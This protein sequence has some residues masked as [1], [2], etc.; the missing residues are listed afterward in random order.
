D[1]LDQERVVA[2]KTAGKNRSLSSAEE[3][4]VDGPEAATTK[5][6]L[7]PPPATASETASRPTA[8]GVG[9][10]SGEQS[11]SSSDSSS[12]SSRSDRRTPVSRLA[13]LRGRF[14]SWRRRKRS[15]V[16]VAVADDEEDDTTAGSSESSNATTGAREPALDPT[17]TAVSEKVVAQIESRGRTAPAADSETVAGRSDAAEAAKKSGEEAVVTSTAPVLTSTPPPDTGGGDDGQQQPALGESSTK[18]SVGGAAAAV[19]SSE[20]AAPLSGPR[21]PASAAALED[22]KLTLPLLVEDGGSVSLEPRSVA[23]IGPPEQE[24]R[25]GGDAGRGAAESGNS[26]A[27]ASETVGLQRDGSASAA[28]VAVLTDDGLSG[29]GVVAGA[30]AGRAREDPEQSSDDNGSGHKAGER[31]PPTIEGRATPSG[32]S[33][34]ST[35]TAVAAPP[36]SSVGTG[37]AATAATTLAASSSTAASPAA[38]LVSDAA[39]AAAAEAL[40]AEEATASS[41]ADLDAARSAPTT[42]AGPTPLP[43][44]RSTD[45]EPG[46]DS[47]KTAP[48]PVVSGAGNGDGE[49]RGSSV[50]KRNDNPRAGAASD[51]ER[52]EKAP[53]VG[54]TAPALK[55]SP[56]QPPPSEAEANP[57]VAAAAGAAAGGA[58]D[59]GQAAVGGD[60]E[61]SSG[62]SGAWGVQPAV[63]FLKGWVE[64]AVPRKKGELKRREDAFCWER[65]WYPVAVVSELRQRRRRRWRGGDGTSVRFEMLGREY[66]L[67]PPEGGTD[68]PTSLETRAWR[69]RSMASPDGGPGQEGEGL[70]RSPTAAAEVP[71]K[72]SS[73]LLW[74]W[75]DTSPAGLAAATL[76]SPASTAA[77]LDD[78]DD[79][80]GG[81]DTASPW[82]RLLL[83]RRRHTAVEGGHSAGRE[84]IGSRRRRRRL[85][86]VVVERDVPC[87]YSEAVGGLLNPGHGEAVMAAAVAAGGGGG[88]EDA[89]AWVLAA[90]TSLASVAD[91][92]SGSAGVFRA[93]SDSPRGQGEVV[94][95]SPTVVGWRFEPTTTPTPPP[96]PPTAAAEEAARNEQASTPAATTA[97]RDQSSSP[98]VPDGE[99]PVVVKEMEKEAVSNAPPRSWLRRR[100]SGGLG[101]EGRRPG[102]G[103][104]ESVR[105]VAVLLP[106]GP[107]H[108]KVFARCV[109]E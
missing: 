62:S 34:T 4:D 25:Q 53:S 37:A 76:A 100:L 29:A 101:A 84:K 40:A 59:A 58:G 18:S 99:L 13:G 82:R 72:E 104:G 103:K 10:A 68:K 27:I 41:E 86:V 50:A 52:R 98:P 6:L 79:W 28:V 95:A 38:G 3:V 39:A 22:E 55:T 83:L 2:L 66:E 51:D 71:V 74:A 9:S 102:R 45:R 49:G 8:G 35:S 11:T 94:F 107:E 88:R 24:E 54:P 96:P 36:L 21:A 61:G 19:A 90:A 67:L 48:P 44:V 14:S 56:E 1:A 17:P 5:V 81:C 93:S 105:Y 32:S 75:P 106:A 20:E 85:E 70:S 47:S 26:T 31:D 42:T 7:L 65:Q 33:R 12:S 46:S 23:A 30:S 109:S 43:R 15:I 80:G 78:D 91:S 77:G 16:A 73:G 97:D 92:S 57:A 89:G 63:E 64:A 69:C 108:T 87:G 60:R